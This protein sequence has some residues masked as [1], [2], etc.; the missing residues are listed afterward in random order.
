MVNKMNRFRK[1]FAQQSETEIITENE[2][3]QR[4]FSSNLFTESYLS[5][6]RAKV[7]AGGIESVRKEI[8]TA[9]QQI[10]AFD[11]TYKSVE[12]FFESNMDESFE[13]YLDDMLEKYNV[14]PVMSANFFQNAWNIYKTKFSSTKGFTALFQQ[15]RNA[16]GANLPRALA[17]LKQLIDKLPNIKGRVENENEF[18]KLVLQLAQ[19]PDNELLNKKYEQFILTE[20]IRDIELG[21]S[22]QTLMASNVVDSKALIRDIGRDEESKWSSV[23]KKQQEYNKAFNTYVNNT[24]DKVMTNF[25]I[26][27]AIKKNNYG[28]LTKDIIE[29][30]FETDQMKEIREMLSI[31]VRKTNLNYIFNPA[32]EKATDNRSR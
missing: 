14:H 7:A 12:S 3:L 25:N 24:F 4:L 31:S 26:L 18:I 15:I 20:F 28:V 19:D 22:D 9:I 32:A 13:A 1:I 16:N 5:E 29:N 27:I 2:R 21:K 8:D 11:D 10:E 30:G 17:Q 23:Q 6:L